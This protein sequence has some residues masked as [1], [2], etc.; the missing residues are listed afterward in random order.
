MKKVVAFVVLIVALVLAF[1]PQASPLR[2]AWRKV[3]RQPSQ[4]A[5]KHAIE[6][7]PDEDAISPEFLQE[8]WGVLL[9]VT[10]QKQD[11]DGSLA[12][13][14][15]ADAA[16]AGLQHKAKTRADWLIYEQISDYSLAKLLGT[17]PK[18]GSVKPQVLQSPEECVSA[19]MA[20]MRSQVLHAHLQQC[21]RVDAGTAR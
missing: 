17:K 18:A 8:A 21:A 9:P 16:M 13:V 2:S 14:G 11:S 15:A 19:I 6:P 7:Q 20:A 12:G 1:L 10:R 4:Q 3:S 5:S